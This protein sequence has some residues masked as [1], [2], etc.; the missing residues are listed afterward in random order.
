MNSLQD[1][2]P[3]RVILVAGVAALG[4]LLFGFDSAV[5]NGTV[6]AIQEEFDLGPGLLGFTVSCA[7]LGAMVGAW[8]S[9]WLAD[10]IGR[11]R[12]MLVAAVLFTA[13][14]VGSGLAFG[15]TDL[16]IWRTIG[17]VGVGMAS[18]LAPAYIAEISPAHSR[19]RLGSMQQLAIVSGIFLAL[20]SNAFLANIAGGSAEEL[21]F[22][23]G[24][25]RWMFLAELV[26]AIAYGLLAL[27]IP[28]S[29]RYLVG[30]QQFVSA[31][32]ILRDVVGIRGKEAAE[33]KI[34]EIKESL[35]LEE[36]QSL[37]DL[38]GA[39]AGLKP[40]VWIGIGL[41]VFQQ[42]VGINVI[43]YYSTT[44][45]QSVG[46]TEADSLTITVLTSVTNIL[47]T[48]V[49][50][51]LVD[52]IG[53]KILL[54]VG[55]A[56]MF[57]SLATMAVSF[58]QA[59][60][61]TGADGE[62]AVS[63]PQPWSIIALIAANLFVVSFGATWGPMVWVLLGE[64]FPNRLRALALGVA[65]SA[66]WLANFTVSQ[67]FPALAAVG[68]PLAYG[69]YAFF[70]FVSFFFVWRFIRETKGMQLEDMNEE[71]YARAP[72]RGHQEGG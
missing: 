32:K 59:I 49:A 15:V 72:Q 11:T 29:P 61:E 57:L 63:L 65:A 3:G 36:R 31:G 2:T 1:K 23:L 16:I 66:Q 9:G 12:S 33:K 45:W 56:G 42:F 71:A 8:M 62:Q 50:I 14:A 22:G 38:R 13:S 35:H 52:K 27:A 7:L 64:M 40:I 28:E 68:L 47:V 21:W 39:A 6:S 41:S 60:V 26:P 20:L 5:I 54:L 69:L 51:L 67:T 19:G 43:F 55:S 18:V 10:N 44:L 37:R 46:F 48:V 70:A 4:G 24:A 58:S 34:A 17:G 25:W 53:R 30:Q